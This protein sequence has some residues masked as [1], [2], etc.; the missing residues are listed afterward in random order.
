M[1]MTSAIAPVSPLSAGARRAGVTPGE[2]SR[3]MHELRDAGLVESTGGEG[4][5][6]RWRATPLGERVAKELELDT[7]ADTAMSP[8]REATQ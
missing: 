8:T 6:E 7:S 5:N 3:A 2:V 1:K 4:A